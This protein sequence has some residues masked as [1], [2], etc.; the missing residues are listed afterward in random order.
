VR[1]GMTALPGGASSDDLPTACGV[2][3][4]LSGPS[5]SYRRAMSLDRSETLVGPRT[6]AHRLTPILPDGRREVAGGGCRDGHAQGH[7]R[8]GG[9]RSTGA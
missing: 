9:D 1:V 3:S 2:A 5:G 4:H 6:C 8:G 7:A